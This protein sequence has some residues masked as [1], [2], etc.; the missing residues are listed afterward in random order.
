MLLLCGN[1]IRGNIYLYL[2]R[3]NT[4][5]LLLLITKFQQYKL[6]FPKIQAH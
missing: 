1:D 6:V 3:W 2:K 5:I 4:I